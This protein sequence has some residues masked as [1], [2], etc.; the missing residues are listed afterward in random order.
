MKVPEKTDNTEEQRIEPLYKVRFPIKAAVFVMA[1]MTLSWFF[2]GWRKI[3]ESLSFTH[4]GLLIFGAVATIF[5]ILVM[6]FWIYAEEKQKGSLVRS[7]ALFEKLY[8]LV[9]KRAAAKTGG[10]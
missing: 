4:V 2:E 10:G 9:M 1:V 5:L 6:S 7:N 3:H 8:Q